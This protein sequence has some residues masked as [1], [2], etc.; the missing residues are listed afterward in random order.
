MQREVIHRLNQ[1][2]LAEDLNNAQTYAHKALTD[3]VHDAISDGVHY[4]GGLVTA[5]SATDVEVSPVRLYQDGV[6]FVAE[7][8]T[9]KSLFQYL[10]ST[11]KKDRGDCGLGLRDR[12]GNDQPGLHHR[13]GERRHRGP[14]G[15]HD[16]PA[17]GYG[18]H[19]W[20]H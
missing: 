20:R 18:G 13:P 8:I 7:Q 6:V 4:S 19:R 14:H 17:P 15:A 9:T 2:I 16:P 5:Q 1:S 10:P 3:V 12:N 11:T